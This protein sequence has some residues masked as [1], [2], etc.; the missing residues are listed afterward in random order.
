M[1]TLK[2]HEKCMSCGRQKMRQNL[3]NGPFLSAFFLASIIGIGLTW[4]SAPIHAQG[5]ALTDAVERQDYPL[6]NRLLDERADV[7]ATQVDGMSS[8]HWAVYHDD[9]D[10]AEK[11]VQVGADVNTETRYGIT[12]LSLAAMNGNG[13][14]VELLLDAGAYSNESLEGGETILMIAARAGSLKAV[15][16]LLAAGADFNAQEQRGQTA[17]M[18]AAAE[19][20][21]SVVKALIDAG[22]NINQKLGSGFTPLFFSV[23]EGHIGVALALIE[24]GVDLNGILS[25]IRERT[26]RAGN[27]ATTQ[28][29]N[30]GLS[31]LL[32]AVRNGHFELAIE[33]VKA[34]ADP[35]DM[36]SGFT[37]L[38][39][40]AWVRKPDASDRGDPPPIGSGNL[41]SLEFVRELV[42][43]GA[44]VNLPLAEGAPRQP[45]SASILETGGST[46]FLLAADRA[47]APL[48]RT[49][50]DLGAN[51]FWSNLSSTTP[52]MA[53]AGLGTRA[54]EE[55]AGTE[56]E[57]LA[58]TSLML[59][60]GADVNAVNENNET[61]M[62]G[63]AYGRFPSVV[64]L[65]ADHGADPHVWNRVN[66]RG[67]TPLFIAEGHRHIPRGPSLP[68][69]EVISRLMFESGIPTEGPRPELI[70]QY[71]VPPNR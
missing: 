64:R 24:A 37:P 52:L 71:E 57:A 34:G 11:L 8:L 49:L 4:V 21:T 61:A 70:D 69:I 33:L 51:P 15:K 28:P 40:V 55:E 68:T 44:D 62:H 30:R 50:L 43:L 48:M 32:L 16:A 18:W 12:A 10:L 7:N 66:Y 19:G 59:E 25:R 39:T 42:A 14:L 9:N 20:H 58:A 56:E 31:P 47:D 17:L 54:P 65:L 53:A 6:I 3:K 67:W 22:G 45:N 63:A 5:S 29:V 36:R 35:N 46:A 13:E 1:Q 38:H 2:N 23:R 26:A 60:L 41:T 27:N